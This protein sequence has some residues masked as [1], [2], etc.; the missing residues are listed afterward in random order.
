MSNSKILWQ[1]CFGIITYTSTLLIGMD[2][3]QDGSTFAWGNNLVHARLHVA[4]WDKE[5]AMTCIVINDDWLLLV[6]C[7]VDHT[8]GLWFSFPHCGMNWCQLCSRNYFPTRLWAQLVRSPLYSCFVNKVLLSLVKFPFIIMMC[9]RLLF[10]KI[11]S[12]ILQVSNHN[13]EIMH[14]FDHHHYWTLFFSI[15]GWLSKIYF[16]FYPYLELCCLSP[17]SLTCYSFP[18]LLVPCTYTV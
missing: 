17:H 12:S 4:C 14:W 18:P 1:P 9:Y 13:L 11:L 7:D 16:P 6:W 3:I 8:L 10:C 2:P 5:F 15:W